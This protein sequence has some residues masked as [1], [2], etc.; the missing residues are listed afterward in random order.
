[1]FCLSLAVLVIEVVVLCF[2]M[3]VLFVEVFNWI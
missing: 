3:I 1:M 2:M